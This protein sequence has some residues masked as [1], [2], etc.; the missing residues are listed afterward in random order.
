MIIL[1]YLKYQILKANPAT[2]IYELNP[3]TNMD[4]FF[5][6]LL[7]IE[8]EIVWMNF[9]ETKSFDGL[10]ATFSLES[11]KSIQLTLTNETGRTYLF[12]PESVYKIDGGVN[13]PLAS[14]KVLIPSGET[15]LIHLDIKQHPH[16]TLNFKPNINKDIRVILFDGTIS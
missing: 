10:K 5:K 12:P 14:D 8:E 11:A 2:E 9:Q 4:N 3:Y 15:K 16:L 7:N 13:Y 1:F 6:Y